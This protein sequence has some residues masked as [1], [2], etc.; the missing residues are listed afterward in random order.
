VQLQAASMP[1]MQHLLT[2]PSTRTKHTTA[3]TSSATL[4]RKQQQQ[5]AKD[6][7]T[8]SGTVTTPDSKTHS[9]SDGADSNAT[10]Q[11]TATT[12]TAVTAEDAVTDANNAKRE[13]LYNVSS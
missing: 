9:N 10:K 11:P 1:D 4:K 6:C 12:V 7:I 8:G 13:E 5:H 2:T 3:G